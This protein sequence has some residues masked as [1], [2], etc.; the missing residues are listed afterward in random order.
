MENRHKILNKE[1]S[2]YISGVEVE[3]A[4]RACAQMMNE[5]YCGS[6]EPVVMLGVLS[7]SMMFMAELSKHLDFAVEW[8]F[9][10]CSSYGDGME[11]SGRVEVSIPPTIEVNGRD[12]LVVEDIVD[13]GNTWEFLHD[14]LTRCGA[15]SVRIASLA[16][17]PTVYDKPLAVDFV[18]LELEDIFV[19]GYGLDYAGLGRNLNGIY[20]LSGVSSC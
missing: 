5:Q 3:G 1:F 10:K 4:V 9:V 11:S 6:P 13:T 17:K 14:Y 8:G 16:L 12:V 19:V 20:R 18:A 7:G 2:P 15:S